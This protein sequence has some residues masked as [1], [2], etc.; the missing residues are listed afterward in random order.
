MHAEVALPVIGSYL[1]ER[2]VVNTLAR[3]L[4]PRTYGYHTHACVHRRL[5]R[6]PSGQYFCLSRRSLD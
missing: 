6:G 2:M 4:L 3:S 5:R 1:R